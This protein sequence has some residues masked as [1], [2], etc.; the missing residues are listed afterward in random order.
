M[1][2]RISRKDHLIHQWMEHQKE[3]QLE[4]LRRKKAKFKHAQERWIALEKTN[5]LVTEVFPGG[6]RVV[7][8]ADQK[9]YLCRYR[10]KRLFQPQNQTYRERTPVAVGDRVLMTVLDDRTGMIEAQGKR[11]NFFDR[12]APGRHQR[13][14]HTLAANLDLLVLIGA[15][16]EPKFN[17][18]TFKPMIETARLKK[19][20]VILL[21]NKMDL[22]RDDPSTLQAQ[23]RE[24]IEPL[25][26]EILFLSAK[27][28]MDIDS[29]E[30]KLL[31]QTTA[32]CGPSGV[33]KTTLLRKLLKRPIGKVQKIS[34]YH[35]EGQHTTSVATLYFRDS[36]TA[37]V[38]TPGIRTFEKVESL[39]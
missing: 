17:L 1:D 26:V 25:D 9:T 5:S 15:I 18:S 34:E 11:K 31:N 30:K 23:I 7:F 3:H 24:Q 12:K 37:W 29:L 2:H 35:E 20:P 22:C 14:V 28:Q 4:P 32:F 36:K 10:R 33:G 21:M 16:E 39:N 8:D 13:W 38:D 19:I 6:C 27:N